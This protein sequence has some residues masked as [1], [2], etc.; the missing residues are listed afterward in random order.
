[1]TLPTMEEFSKKVAEETL[2][3][4]QVTINDETM[5]LR[6]FLDRLNGEYELVKKKEN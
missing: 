2:N 3:E 6:E 5:S 1:M 4:I